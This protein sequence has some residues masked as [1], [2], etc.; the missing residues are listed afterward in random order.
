MTGTKTHW[1]RRLCM[2]FCVILIFTLM[3]P[4]T[5]F[6]DTAVVTTGSMYSY[7]QTYGSNG[8]WKDI[9]TPSHWITSTGEVAYCLQTSMD[10]PYNSSYSTVDGSSYYSDY[11]LS[12]LMAILQNGYPATNGGFTDE[13]AR[14]ATANAIRFFLAENYADGVPQYLNLNVNGD[15]IR[16]KS[17]YE[18]L[19]NWALSLVLLARQGATSSG[20]GSLSFSPSAITLTEEPGGEYFSGSITVNKGISGSYGMYSDLP[21]GSSIS[22]Y[23]GD[24]T[25]TINVRVP[26]AFANQSYSICAYGSHQGTEAR[27]FFWAPSAANQQ[28]IVTYV[29]DTS[30]NWVEAYATVNTP[31]ATVRTGSLQITKTDENGDPLSGVSFALYDENRNLLDCGWTES[32]GTVT[33]P[34]LSLGDYYYRE[35]ET[36][37]GYILDSA[38]HAVTISEGG[39]VVSVTVQNALATGSVVITKTDA[40]SGAALSG[41]HFVLKDAD[42]TT[43]DEGDTGADGTL[44]F[45]GLRLETYTLTETATLSGYI[46]DSTLI[47]I[48]LTANGQ[49]VN[50]SITNTRARGSVSIVKTDSE[51]GEALAGVHFALRD[52]NGSTVAEGDTASD[53]TLMLPNIPLGN[54]TLVETAAATGYVPDETPREVIITENGQTVEIAVQND[55]IHSSLEITKQD[56]HE[57]TV[58][59]GAGYRLYDSTG[60]QVA[61]GYTDAFGKLSFSDLP[62]GEYSYQEFKAPKGYVLDGTNYPVS[63]TGNGMS[64]TETRTNERRPGTLI[65]KKQSAD[66]SPL[67]GAAFLLEYSTDQ[68]STWQPVFYRVGDELSSGGCTAQNLDGGELTTGA[69]GKVTFTGLRADELILYRLTETQAPPGRSLL[70]DSILVGRLPVESDNIYAE[71]TEVFDAKAFHYTLNITATDNPQY[72]LPEAGGS[73]FSLLTVA[74]M[75]MAFPITISLKSKM[76]KENY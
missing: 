57:G 21:S 76:K 52:G 32:N 60:T 6:A 33:F 72:R 47:S 20:S 24:Q 64:I 41:V 73:G 42:G 19:Y 37:P 71:D 23:T 17:G 29:L 39:Q 51:T 67:E 14:Y 46:P 75:L 40:D 36:L 4:I 35:T 2:L 10:P 27:L 70:G 38:Y 9:Q 30:S 66:G 34:D 56:A 74:M 48:E 3:L 61:E 55:P 59:M 16:G 49:T 31:S 7:F 44:T 28:R 58:L 62:R 69:D 25:E 43:V 11:V 15:W 13:Q 1:R 53:G 18:S 68:G 54:Y 8:V 5:A 26:I 45:S 63:I 65:V 22:N 12:G 50:K